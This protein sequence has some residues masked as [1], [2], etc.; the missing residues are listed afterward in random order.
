M[1]DKN[2]TIYWKH[3]YH[4]EGSFNIE[5][6]T[7]ELAAFWS[8]QELA[9]DFVLNHLEDVDDEDAEDLERQMFLDNLEIDVYE[10]VCLVRPTSPPLARH[11]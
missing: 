8:A 2:Y 5:T 10:G 1:T 6:A 11:A 3:S 9:G 7:P 4:G